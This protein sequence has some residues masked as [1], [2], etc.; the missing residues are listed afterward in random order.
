MPNIGADIGYKNA[1]KSI[2]LLQADALQIHV[3]A[4]QE[5]IMPEGD[6]EFEHWLTNIKEIKEHISVP[7]IIKEVGFGMS[8]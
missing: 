1:Q 6:T 2:D 7:V 3:N 8:A 5:L 4:P